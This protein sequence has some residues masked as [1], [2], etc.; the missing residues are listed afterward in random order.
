MGQS[1]DQPYFA[2]S[3][4]GTFAPNS[5]PVIALNAWNVDS[6]EFRVYRVNDPVQFFE[7]LESAH[8]FGGRAP[9]PPHERTWLERIHAWKHSLRTGI[10]LGLRSQFNESPSARLEG[11]LPAS[12]K[13]APGPGGTQYAVAPLLNSQQL[14]LSFNHAVKSRNRWDSQPVELAVKDRGVYLVE[15]VRGELRAYTLL[16]VSDLVMVTK[17]GNGRIVNFLADRSTGEPVRGAQIYLLARDA[18]KATAE[19]DASGLAEIPLTDTRS[20]DLRLVARSGPNYAVTTLAA[21]AFETSRPQ[22]MGYIYTDR[23]VYRPGHTVH[24]KGILRQRTAGGYTTPAG[25]SLA[26]EIQ[27]A[28]QKPVYRKTLTANANGTVRDE[29]TLPPSST[30]GSYSINVRSGEE[31]YMN[32][33]FE[34]EEYKKPEYEVRV[35]AAKPRIL[36]GEQAQAVIDSRYYFGE[37][38]AGAKVKYAVYRGVYWFPMWYDPDEEATPEAGDA[39][40]NDYGDEQIA[41][42]EGTLDAEGKLTDS[43][44]TPPFPST[45]QTTGTGSRRASPMKASAKSWAAAG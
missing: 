38:V 16:M 14:V 45:G 6:L 10:R 4:S 26:V 20:D 32:G 22:W 17:T 13:P 37:P 39:D 43:T 44:S 2:I 42:E 9:K 40:G 18:R 5:K 28:E 1:E 12:S 30:L 41:D 15:A 3:S 25:K 23:P 8:E 33:S 7:Q 24:F 36:E 29:F 11:I 21:Y 35:T 27:D 34:V 19:S 31:N